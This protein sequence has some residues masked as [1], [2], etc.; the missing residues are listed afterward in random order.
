MFTYILKRILIFIP[1][2]IIISIMTFA[3]SKFAPG[4]SVK[5]ALGNR[6]QQGEGG[7]S[8]DKLSTEKAYNAM[9][10]Q[11]GFTLPA[12][13]VNFTSAATPDTLYKFLKKGE[14][15]NLER[16]ISEYGNWKE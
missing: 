8:S 2:L 14:R 4:D 6:E 9:A 11:L 12:F 10:E 3:L 1:T 15:D 7:G 5:Q 16:L 13:Y